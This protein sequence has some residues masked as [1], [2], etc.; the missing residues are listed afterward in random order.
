MKQITTAQRL[1]RRKNQTVKDVREERD[2]GYARLFSLAGENRVTV[3]WGM[4][5]ACRRD[6]I[7]KITIG[8]KY[9]YLNA[10]DVMRF[11]RWS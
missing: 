2:S 4:N 3:E 10:E 9:A 1:Q 11:L 6:G 8:D 5:E 7:C